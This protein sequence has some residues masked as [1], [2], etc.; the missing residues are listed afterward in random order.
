MAAAIGNLIFLKG[1]EA[2]FSKWVVVILVIE[3]G[4][5]VLSASVYIGTRRRA[6]IKVHLVGKLRQV[7]YLILIGFAI[8]NSYFNIYNIELTRILKLMVALSFATFVFYLCRAWTIFKLP[9]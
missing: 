6:L 2:V 7:G 3:L 8:T 4:I 1:A 5:F 9:A